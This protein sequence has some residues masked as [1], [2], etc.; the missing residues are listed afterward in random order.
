MKIAVIHYHLK[1]GGVTTVIRRQI[2]GT[3]ATHDFLL[4]VGEAPP[5]SGA[6][7]F[8]ADIVCL[9][10]IGY[11]APGKP[12][13]NDSAAAAAGIMAA[14]RKKW[15]DGC[16]LIHSHNPL[17]AKNKSFLSILDILH[18][19]GIKLFLQIHDLAEDGRPN[20]YY[21]KQ[22]YPTACHYGVINSR[23]LKILCDAGAHPKGVHLLPNAVP[24]L[25]AVGPAGDKSD[26]NEV[27]YPVRA[28]RRKN[29]GEAILLSLFFDNHKKLA[30][31][32][33]PNSPADIPAY[34]DWQSFVKQNNLPVTFEASS[35]R[36]FPELAANARSII[37]TSI[38]EGFG[39]S[40]LEPWTAKKPLFGRQLPDICIDFENKGIR[41]DHLYPRLSVP[42]DW[43]DRRQFQEKIQA[44]VNRADRAFG[45]VLAPDKVD[46]LLTL[47]Q[48]DTI[49][50]GLLDEALQ[51]QV[52]ARILSSPGARRRLIELN[53]ALIEQNQD[54][55]ENRIA[56]NQQAINRHFS[57]F[58]CGQAL[59]A[60]YREVAETTVL[61]DLDK[62]AILNCFFNPETFTLLKWGEYDVR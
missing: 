28:I 8:Q 6:S 13:C 5:D 31:T 60:V 34:R 15:P 57:S 53:P 14:I 37:T 11:D 24:P 33:G 16:D 25:P 29:I 49:D 20:H 50:F 7:T 4:I 43:L 59:S 42:G 2:E 52:L 58:Q 26:D 36:P 30:I 51:K 46:A 54:L 10:E 12:A 45:V 40:F 35:R 1:P 39:F 17:L 38:S 27:L 21:S 47:A 32:L 9:P 3:G 41:L 61:H 19:K 55:P 44:A 48:N 23:D 18:N 22:P 56:A 62:A